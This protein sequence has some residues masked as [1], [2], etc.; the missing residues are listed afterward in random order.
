M[1]DRDPDIEEAVA[2]PF[3]AAQSMIDYILQ[4]SSGAMGKAVALKC[5]VKDAG[6]ELPVGIGHTALQH[7]SEAA[8]P[9]LSARN[10]LE[11]ARAAFEEAFAG[12]LKD[13]DCFGDRA[14]TPDEQ[15]LQETVSD[16]DIWDKPLAT[17]PASMNE[18]KIPKDPEVLKSIKELA[19]ELHLGERALERAIAGITETMT[20]VASVRRAMRLPINVAQSAFEHLGAAMGSLI[21]ARAQLGGGHSAL[22]E[23]H[24]AFLRGHRPV[25]KIVS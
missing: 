23:L 18:L 3:L 10:S 2:R 7:L 17:K 4:Y 25:L 1:A 9:V 5:L 15:W 20:G 14:E 16:E 21:A 24:Q 12:M 8:G 13:E 19:W 22:S 11:T 6:V